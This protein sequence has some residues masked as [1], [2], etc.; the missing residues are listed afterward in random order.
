M[1]LMNPFEE[2]E[3]HGVPTW[4]QI[5]GGT[6][7]RGVYDRVGNPSGIGTI[8]AQF[9]SI[10]MLLFHLEYVLALRSF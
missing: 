7:S 2:N 8:K 4:P 9:A 5:T 10:I 3:S 6:N 1:F